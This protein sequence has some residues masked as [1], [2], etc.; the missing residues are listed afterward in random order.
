MGSGNECGSCAVSLIGLVDCNNF[1]VSCER[2]FRPDLKGKPVVV[3][4]S[5]DGCA[6]A[7]S[8]EAKELGVKMGEPYFKF[9]DIADKFNLHIFSSNF[10]LYGSMSER[11][12]ATLKILNPHV[13]VYS[14]DEA[15]LE[16]AGLQNLFSWVQ[17]IKNTVQQW[18][19]IPIS[20]GVSKTK[21]LAKVANHFSK[22]RGAPLILEEDSE[23]DRFL[24]QLS[25][26]RIW[27]IGYK[28]ARYL[29]SQGIDTALK[30]KKAPLK[31]IRQK[32]TVVGERIVAE[33][34]GEKVYHLEEHPD[35]KKSITVSRSFRDALTNKED[36][37]QAI[38]AFCEK[39]GEKLRQE[40]LKTKGLTVFIKTNRFKR[41]HYYSNKFYI[42]LP[43]STHYTPDLLRATREGFEK[44]FRQGL[45][46]KRAGISLYPL[47]APENFQ[48]DFFNSPSEKTENL[49]SLIDG[50]NRIYGAR[51]LTYGSIGIKQRWSTMRGNLS[52]QYTTNW[53]ELLRV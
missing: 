15:F 41:D 20:V 5:N 11:V 6:I 49:I 43:L 33:L 8:N 9:K 35:S 47:T 10:A 1:F 21:T 16:I 2:V 50:I 3:L 29:L 44:I 32:M 53:D 38:Y 37:L 28:S 45:S 34:N 12:M 26:D 31:W 48:H 23:I 27:G 36:L 25:V 18:T 22:K 14:I 51:T 4:S 40:K 46:Y 17:H 7:R 30:L 19:G 24:N 42:D 52:P 39:S 13:E